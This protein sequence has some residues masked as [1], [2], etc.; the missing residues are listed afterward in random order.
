MMFPNMQMKRDSPVSD[1]LREKIKQLVG[2]AAVP[3]LD[4]VQCDDPGQAPAMYHTF[5]N[6]FICK[7]GI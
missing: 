7:V 2:G 6:T 5:G 1:R 4:L 3:A